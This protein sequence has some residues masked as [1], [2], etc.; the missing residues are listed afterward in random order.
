MKLHTKGEV[1]K[2]LRYYNPEHDTGPD[3]PVSWREERLANAVLE[4]QDQLEELQMK[5]SRIVDQL[6]GVSIREY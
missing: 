3:C 1:E 2:I 6:P 4:L 5:V